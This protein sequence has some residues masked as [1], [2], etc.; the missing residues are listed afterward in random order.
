MLLLEK[1]IGHE[2]TKYLIENLLNNKNR[3]GFMPQKSCATN[4]IGSLDILTDA[5]NNC[6]SVDEVN[7]DFSKEFDEVD[8]DL[9]ILKISVGPWLGFTMVQ[10]LVNL[11]W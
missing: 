8:H 5:L 10:W 7:T 6:K 4:L 9:M 11:P 3:H 1:L 2:M